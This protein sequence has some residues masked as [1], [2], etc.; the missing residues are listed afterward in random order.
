MKDYDVVNHS[1]GR[2]E[3]FVK[4]LQNEKDQSIADQWL[5]DNYL[6]ALKQGRNGLGTVIVNSAGNERMEGGNANYSYLTS[7]PYT[8][9]VGAATLDDNHKTVI[10]PY[11]NA[12]ASVLV[13]AH[14]SNVTTT[15]R[16]LINANGGTLGSDAASVNGTSYSAPIVTGIIALMLEANPNLG[17]R[18]VQEILSL[19]A[20]SENVL[21]GD[22][23]WNG[24]STWNNGGRHV[25]HDFGYGLVDAKAAVRLAENWHLQS[26]YDNQTRLEHIYRS[27]KLDQQIDDNSG[28]Q[29]SVTVNSSTLRVENVSVT[30]NLTHSR[31]SDVALKLISP[32][33]TESLL[34]NEA[35]KSQDNRRRQNL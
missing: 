31:A 28:R 11:S 23:Q 20:T 14:G 29:F 8:V 25:S 17:Y 6:S 22:W 12:G 35:G 9:V 34:L 4:Q 19:T 10:A 13:S 3:N 30:V 18:D 7:A 32:S 16:R 15:S 26:T 21:T 5:T 24:D 33:G 2:K 27:G 1:W